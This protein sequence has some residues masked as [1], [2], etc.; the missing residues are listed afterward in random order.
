M[1]PLFSL[2]TLS[3]IVKVLIANRGEI[4][5][6][7]IRACR[8]LGYPTVAVYS[9]ADRAALH[10]LYAQQAMHVGPSPSSESYLRIDHI[11]DAAR[12]SGAEAVHPGYGFLAENADFAEACVNAGLIFIG[13]SP[14][15][16]RAMGSKTESRQRMKAAGVPIVPGLERAV[17]S[18]DEIRAFADDA[19]L[20]VMIKASAGG[21]GKGMRLVTSMADLQPAFDR[22]RSEAASFFGDAAVYAEKFVATP[23]HIEVQVLGDHHGSLVHLGERE[24]TLQRRNQKVVEESPSPVVDEELRAKL[25]ETAVRAAAAVGYYSAGTIEFLMDVDRNFYFLEMNTRLQVEHPV[26]EL[27]TGIDL[28][29]QQLRIA[30]GERLDI[31]QSDVRMSGHAIECRIY[32]EDP[33]ANFA[34]SPGLI[35]YLTLPEGPGIRNDNGVL[36]G[37]TV[38]IHYDPMLSK[39]IVHGA[40]REEA[41]LRMRRALAEYRIDGIRTTISFYLSVMNDPAFCAGDFDTGFIDRM[42]PNLDLDSTEAGDVE[43]AIAASAIFMFEDSEKVRLPT[44]GESAWGRMAKLDAVGRGD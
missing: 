8:E 26:T 23:R 16:I 5:V 40:D 29:K 25:G 9:D 28:V 7:I 42:L 41:R 38:P 4:A 31:S 18:F 11:L 14:E 21:G 17:E 12:R 19:G 10:V 30:Q 35:R 13:P 20:P 6:R 15:A 24:C 44:G 1:K 2:F 27:V 3:T 32:A 34:P 22:V 36:A 37:Y 43:A 39:L 33:T